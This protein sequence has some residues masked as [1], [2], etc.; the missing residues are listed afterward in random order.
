MSELL[1]VEAEGLGKT[2]N[3]GELATVAARARRLIRPGGETT[4][5]PPFNALRD[6]SFSLAAGECLGIVGENGSGK[7]TL[8][9]LIAGITVPNA[10]LLRVRGRVLPLLEVGAVFHDELTG[11]ENVELFGAVL[12]INPHAVATAMPAIG[13]FAGI[14]DDHMDTPM[15]R[16]S[17]G[18]RARLSFAVA[19]R[20]PAE[21][22]I[23]DEVMA[24]VDD[25]FRAL[26]LREIEQLIEAR[27]TVIVISHDLEVVRSL[28]HKGL[29]LDRGTMQMFGPIDEVADAYRAAEGATVSAR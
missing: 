25:H 20:F 9:Q 19:M 22:Y 13:E 16:F 21:I 17:T 27:A 2:Y 29:W 15:K 23:F 3:L 24:V 7:S 26:A 12:G 6:V 14:D 1:A 5:H 8:V 10:G 28:A 4:H 11:R 18:M